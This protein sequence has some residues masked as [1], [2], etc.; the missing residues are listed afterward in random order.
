MDSVRGALQHIGSSLQVSKTAPTGEYLPT[1]SFIIRGKKNFLPPQ[2]LIMGLAFM[3]RLVRRC[4]HGCQAVG[5]AAMP[6]VSIL[7]F[8]G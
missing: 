1:G 2:P 5:R 3:F 6:W 8:R 4:R 7:G